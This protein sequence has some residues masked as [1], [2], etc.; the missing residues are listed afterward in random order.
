[1]DDGFLALPTEIDPSLMKQA[2][3]EL[4]WLYNLR[5]KLEIRKQETLNR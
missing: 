2:F 5:W 4:Q 1:M 3:N